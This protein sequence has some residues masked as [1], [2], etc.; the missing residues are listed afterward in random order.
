M[1]RCVIDFPGINADYR[2]AGTVE[3]NDD[4]NRYCWLKHGLCS[5]AWSID[6][7]ETGKRKQLY[8]HYFS[9]EDFFHEFSYDQLNPLCQAIILQSSFF[10]TQ[11]RLTIERFDH[12]R[13]SWL[14]KKRKKKN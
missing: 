6:A 7:W 3:A 13:K 1:H 12:G 8:D 9:L 4:Q 10:R 2:Q 5:G 14:I 11:Y